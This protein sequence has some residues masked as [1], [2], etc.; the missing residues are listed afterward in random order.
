MLQTENSHVCSQQK[1]M[2]LRGNFKELGVP[3]YQESSQ[4]TY[5]SYQISMFPVELLY[6]KMGDTFFH[7]T[8][9]TS[10]VLVVKGF[11]TVLQDSQ[12]IKQMDDT[13]F[14]HNEVSLAARLSLS[15]FSLRLNPKLGSS[16]GNFSPSATFLR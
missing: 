4:E 2:A 15:I 8:D 11:S 6:S 5:P 1:L 3:N 10:R 13:F 12:G 16:V 7:Q 14:H 9:A